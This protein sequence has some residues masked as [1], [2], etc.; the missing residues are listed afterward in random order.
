[1]TEQ[2]APQPQQSQAPP[3][4]YTY[5]NQMTDAEKSL[6]SLSKLLLESSKTLST[7]R[8]EFRGE[9]LQQYQD[10]SVA[11]IQVSK[12]VFVKVDPKTEQPIM[13][14]IT[15]P[16]EEGAEPVTREVYVA[17]DEAIEEIL[18]M[19][20]FVGINQITPITSIGE[21]NILDDLKEFECKLAAT[22]CL[23]QKEWGIDKELLPMM[24]TKIKTIV[25]DARYMCCK[26]AILRAL[27]TSVQRVE[28]AWEGDRG[29]KSMGMRSPYS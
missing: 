5:P 10:G 23:K 9:A 28:Q 4:N 8:R 13:R 11:Y 20:K 18:S 3:I 22:L 17:N 2:Q 1:M 14:E 19:L 25:Q 24:Q 6:A 26:G 27:Q 12:P 15:L 7:L 21:G 16:S 29:G